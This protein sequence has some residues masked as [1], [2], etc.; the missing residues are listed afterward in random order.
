MKSHPITR[1]GSLSQ[2]QSRSA[3]VVADSVRNG[4]RSSRFSAS[5]NRIILQRPADSS[6]KAEARR[7]VLEIAK[8][9]GHALARAD[10]VGH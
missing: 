10:H 8:G 5:R 9:L 4:S 6:A 2:L 1:G 3:A 7:I